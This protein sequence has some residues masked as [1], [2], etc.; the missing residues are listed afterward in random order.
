MPNTIT[1]SVTSYNKLISTLLDMKSEN[2][3]IKCR[4]DDHNDHENVH[5]HD[6]YDRTIS[7]KTELSSTR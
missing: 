6:R 4:L 1:I 7:K 2:Y 3:R 5:S